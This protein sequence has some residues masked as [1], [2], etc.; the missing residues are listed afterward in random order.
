MD[1]INYV[2]IFLGELERVKTDIN[3]I[4]IGE[5][6]GFIE[7]T[8]MLIATFV[9]IFTVKEIEEY[10]ED[11]I[12]SRNFMVFE[13]NNNSVIS[14]DSDE[15]KKVLTVFKP[16][17]DE[18]INPLGVLS[19]NGSFENPLH[20]VTND[21]HINSHSVRFED[22]LNVDALSIEERKE[23]VEEI[24]SKKKLSDSDKSL[25]NKLTTNL[26]DDE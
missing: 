1:R 8:G 13:Y 6:I 12:L 2:A 17:I 4:S 21:T 18:S 10:F 11:K 7:P 15:L 24:L 14:L 5:N 3:S 20:F 19:G 9:S 25:L 16:T 23:M 26:Y 22:N